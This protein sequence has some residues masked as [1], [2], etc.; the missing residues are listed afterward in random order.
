MI[1]MTRLPRRSSASGGPYPVE[2]TTCRATG[3]GG[4]AGV[5]VQWEFGPGEACVEVGLLA[6]SVRLWWFASGGRSDD[7]ASNQRKEASMNL[8]TITLDKDDAAAQAEDYRT[9]RAPT[10]EDK[11]ILAG[12]LAA[13]A[14]KQLLNLR[15]ALRAG[16]QDEAHL[17]KL[18]VGWADWQWCYLSRRQS[19][20]VEFDSSTWQHAN[21][22]RFEFD[23]LLDEVPYQAIMPEGARYGRV[24]S[25]VPI[26]P[27]ALR[28]AKSYL[29]RFAILWEVEEWAEAPRPPGD[30]ALL[31]H[32]TGDLW[33]VEA[34]WM[35]TPLEQA[36]LGA[37]Q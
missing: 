34:V 10:D 28:P 37:R 20:T 21:A 11:A 12:L 36:V 22:R 17:P 16:G 23:G 5:W 4:T 13:S 24:R 27:P 14:G 3:D 6:W 19:G 30:P 32:I 29:R 7:R 2:L 33:T 15:D 35:L 9:L 25:Q 8:D 1:E 26:I 18:A 31:R